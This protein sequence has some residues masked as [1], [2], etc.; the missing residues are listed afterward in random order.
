MHQKFPLSLAQ[1]GLLIVVIPLVVASCVAGALWHGLDEMDAQSQRLAHAKAICETIQQING[2]MLGIAKAGTLLDL[3]NSEKARELSLQKV[4]LAKEGIHELE[5]ETSTSQ[6]EHAAFAR[7]KPQLNQFIAYMMNDVD[8]YLKEHPG[9]AE[10]RYIVK[11]LANKLGEVEKAGIDLVNLEK[12]IE[13]QGA[14]AQVNSRQALIDWM[15]AG[16]TSDTLLAALIAFL[17]YRQILVKLNMLSANT[18]RLSR[19][20]A[21]LPLSESEDELGH[22]DRVFHNM[23]SSLAEAA[24]YRKQMIT[25]V[26]NDLRAPLTAIADGLSRLAASSEKEPLSPRAQE[27]IAIARRGTQR[28]VDL[29]ND[30][31]DIEKMEGGKLTVE[32][33]I[34][35]SIMLCQRAIEAVK[36]FAQEHMIDVSLSGQSY[37]LNVD[38]DKV[39]QVLV[40]L[41]SNAVKFS[42]DGS[43]VKVHIHLRGESIEFRVSDEGPGIA[44]E[45]Q[46][47]I[48]NKFQPV[49]GSSSTKLKGTGLGLAISKA[50]IEGHNGEIGLESEV[51]HGST[52]WFRLPS[53]KTIDI[54]C[55]ATAPADRC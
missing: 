25:L 10:Q 33:S 40:N 18:E 50:I 11:E 42:P 52:F 9:Y 32:P 13:M 48:F 20:E 41:L 39:V 6:A 8:Y 47:S 46:Q 51:G 28:L 22:L 55:R 38:A 15:V 23:A 36:A 34:T 49:P 24:E 31:L 4:Q 2:A 43:Q 45:Y 3:L 21:L 27:Q 16:L 37:E 12:D 35:D 14:L 5:D 29:V 17:F 1:K 19:N 7:L 53:P 44:P 26:G 30:L 54:T